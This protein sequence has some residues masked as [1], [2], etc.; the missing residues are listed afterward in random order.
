MRAGEDA[1]AA[2]RKGGNTAR[3]QELGAPNGLV[4]SSAAKGILIRKGIKHGQS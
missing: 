1:E 3:G 2:R 4:V